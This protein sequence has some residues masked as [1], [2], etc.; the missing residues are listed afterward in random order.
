MLYGIPGFIQ[1]AALLA[2]TDQR[3]ASVEMK[4]LY[5]LRRDVVCAE[6]EKAE[7]LPLLKPQAAMYVMADIRAYGLSGYDFCH[8]LY[9]ET[10]VSVLDAGAFGESAKG[11]IRISFT[12]GEDTLKEGCRR[13]V[14]FL[15]TL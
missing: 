1:Q 11:W 4:E 6:L 15:N 3:D 14:E 9:K 10:G 2:L 13:I 12:L 5:R 7:N 8:A